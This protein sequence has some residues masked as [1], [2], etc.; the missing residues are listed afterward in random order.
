MQ[1]EIVTYFSIIYLLPLRY[2]YNNNACCNIF[3][4]TLS[5]IQFYAPDSRANEY[6]GL[7]PNKLS[8]DRYE[9]I[10]TK[11]Q[12]FES[13]YFTQEQETYWFL[14]QSDQ[15][16]VHLVNVNDNSPT[17]IPDDPNCAIE[18]RENYD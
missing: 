15:V 5:D 8:D 9:L 13:T 16:A 11:V 14:I 6:L 7:E 4:G 2:I 18:V 3:A 1:T 17:I 10:I 12:D